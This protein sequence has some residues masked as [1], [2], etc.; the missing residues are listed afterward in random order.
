MEL[1]QIQSAIRR[2]YA[3]VARQPVGQFKYPVGRVSAEQL[4]YPAKLV[5]RVPAD[6]VDRFV[7]V[8]NPFLLGEPQ[9]GWRVVDVGCGVG[10][11]S[12][13]AAQYIGPKGQVV[14]V[15]MSPEMLNAARAGRSANLVFV[16]G[17]AEAL[18]L[19]SGWADLVISNGVLNLSP[20]KESA[21]AEVARVLRPGGRFQA[22][23]LILVKDLPPDLHHDEF[24]WSN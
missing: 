15:D 2:R 19:E 4:G 18:P 9:S 22:A 16:Q 24:A 8:G 23:D 12:R 10:F 11:D 7:G 1:K 14:G 20:C 6:V 17:C 13:M 3:E 5:G 21:F